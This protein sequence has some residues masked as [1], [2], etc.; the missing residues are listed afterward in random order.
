MRLLLVLAVPLW[1]FGFLLLLFLFLHFS[2]LLGS[3]S[4]HLGR[5]LIISQKDYLNSSMINDSLAHSCQNPHTLRSEIPNDLALVICYCYRQLANLLSAPAKHAVRID[6][7]Q[8][9]IQ[10]KEAQATC[11]QERE[12]K[13]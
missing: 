13:S 12:K 11:P 2:T 5:L 6:A 7:V 3:L 1:K 8:E 9:E 10:E 4:A